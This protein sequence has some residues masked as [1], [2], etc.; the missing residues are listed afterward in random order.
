MRDAGL[1]SYQSQA[2]RL[3]APDGGQKGGWGAR[4]N[5]RSQATGGCA[6]EGGIMEKEKDHSR[7]SK[8]FRFI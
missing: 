5:K 2:R 7:R 1:F 6:G 4:R 8:F 3:S